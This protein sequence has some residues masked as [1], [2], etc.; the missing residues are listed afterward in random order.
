M[1]AEGVDPLWQPVQFVFKI[2]NTVLAKLTFVATQ[3]PEATQ[4]L[5]F[6]PCCI[7]FSSVAICGEAKGPLGGIYPVTMLR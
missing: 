5:F 3:L 1:P 2:G 4:E 7:H 6:A